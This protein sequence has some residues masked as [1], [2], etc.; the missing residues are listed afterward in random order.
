MKN[1]TVFNNNTFRLYIPFRKY[2]DFENVLQKKNIDYSI[3]FEM[4]NSL[5]DFARF[6]FDKRDEKLVNE[7][8]IENKIDAT[9]DFFVPADYK[10]EQKTFL[11]YLKFFGIL[12][13]C[14]FIYYFIHNFIINKN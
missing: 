6:Y 13:L 10:K 12:L 5:T 14:V 2:I 9:D 1:T 4:P 3:D 11:L 8:L 7:L